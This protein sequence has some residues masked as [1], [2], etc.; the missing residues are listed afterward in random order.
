MILGHFCQVYSMGYPPLSVALISVSVVFPTLAFVAVALRVKARL[1]KRTRLDVS[2]YSIF[3]ACVGSPTLA[4]VLPC[5]KLN[6]SHVS[7][8]S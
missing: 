3:L 7:A 1:I 5:A 8:N 6:S 4:E 2:D